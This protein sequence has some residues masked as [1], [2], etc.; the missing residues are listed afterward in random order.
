MGT[1][2]QTKPSPTYCPTCG[3]GGGDDINGTWVSIKRIVINE[4]SWSGE[5]LFLPMNLHGSF[6]ISD[7]MRAAFQSSALTNFD[8]IPIEH[9]SKDYRTL[10]MPA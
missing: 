10:R 8:A 3:P 9:Y 7:T 1:I 2:W 5:Q 6:I 4:L